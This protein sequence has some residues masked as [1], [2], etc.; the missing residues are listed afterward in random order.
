MKLTGLIPPPMEVRLAFALALLPKGPTLGILPGLIGATL[1]ARQGKK[2]IKQYKLFKPY[3]CRTPSCK[4]SIHSF[5]TAV[6]SGKT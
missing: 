2:K 1:A 4:L 6:K 5:I 3:T